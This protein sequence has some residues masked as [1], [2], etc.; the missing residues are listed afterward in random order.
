MC[1]P[2][3]VI[4]SPRKSPILGGK[5]F[6]GSPARTLTPAPV[7]TESSLTLPLQESPKTR[8]GQP[9]SLFTFILHPAI[10]GDYF[11][12]SPREIGSASGF[13]ATHGFHHGFVETFVG[14]PY[15]IPRA[16]V[17]NAHRLRRGPQAPR[18]LNKLQQIHAPWSKRDL[19]S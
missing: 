9:D 3:V 8:Q 2:L 15:Q 13:S 14:V 16:H 7:N 1:S 6:A 10:Q 18:F 11:P 19:F 5:M 17:G 12:A 4:A